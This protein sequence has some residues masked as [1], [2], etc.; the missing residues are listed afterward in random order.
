MVVLLLLAAVF[1][2]DVITLGLA[3]FFLLVKFLCLLLCLPAPFLRELVSSI[4]HLFRN[5]FS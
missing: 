2:C 5:S 4:C 1:V 3:F